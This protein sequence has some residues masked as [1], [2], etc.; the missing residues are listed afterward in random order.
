MPEVRFG[1]NC[2]IFDE[3]HPSEL[4]YSQMCEDTPSSGFHSVI[5]EYDINKLSREITDAVSE[6]RLEDSTSLIA[7]YEVCPEGPR[8]A[9]DEVLKYR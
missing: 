8:P 4:K 7:A 2:G 3:M 6:S 1:E 9:N 5:N